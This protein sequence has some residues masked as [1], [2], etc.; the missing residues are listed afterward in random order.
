MVTDAMK[1]N[2]GPASSSNAGGFRILRIKW[3]EMG[4]IFH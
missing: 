3:Q 2:P 4:L 1:T